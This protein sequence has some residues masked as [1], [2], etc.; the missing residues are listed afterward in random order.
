MKFRKSMA[1][2]LCLNLLLTICAPMLPITAKAATVSAD[3]AG[4]NV[5][6]S[7]PVVSAE[8]L[9]KE[10]KLVRTS[11]GTESEGFTYTLTER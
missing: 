6:Q 10:N 1:L 9:T 3:Q 8:P 2:I 7:A 4:E 11:E 5:A